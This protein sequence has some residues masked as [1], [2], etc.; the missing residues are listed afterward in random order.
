MQNIYEKVYSKTSILNVLYIEDDEFVQQNTKELLEDLFGKVEIASNGHEGLEKYLQ[1]K[2][3]DIVITDINMP[4]M[5]G[6]EMI[7][8]IKAIKDTQEFIV[9]S[10]HN[11]SN[12]LI[13]LIELNVNS[14]VLKPIQREAF[15]DKLYTLSTKI[16]NDKCKDEYLIRQHKLAKMGD[17]IDMIA[18][19]WLNQLNVLGLQLQ[20][21][22]FEI[23]LAPNINEYIVNCMKEQHDG[24]IFLQET[25]RE[26]RG[27]FD[28]SSLKTLITFNEL[29]DSVLFLLNGSLIKYNI[30]FI[31][32]SKESVDLYLNKNEFK[33]ILINLIQNSIDAFKDRDIE[34]RIITIDCFTTENQI[35]IEYQD[36]AGGIPKDIIKDIF[37]PR[38]TSKEYGTGMGIY[39]AKLI[40]DKHEGEIEVSNIH[41]G[42]NFKI[43]LKKED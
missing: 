28:N 20:T 9:I 38:V 12:Y 7:K 43:I 37:E 29:L 11:E 6:I 19:Q 31:N 1:Y 21:A 8:K 30:N 33:H 34:N 42:A 40:I 24:Q 16:C 39:L 27:F 25:L 5:N 23:K 26:F 15:M 22:E 13:D 32:K 18:H 35:I 2:D 41:D 36:N 10:A 14:F 4:H 17:M 3:F